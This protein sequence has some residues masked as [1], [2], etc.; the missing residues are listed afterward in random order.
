ML[1]SQ[2]SIEIL[3]ICIILIITTSVLSI[4]SFEPIFA[5]K[6]EKDDNDDD[7]KKNDKDRLIFEVKIFLQELERIG[8]LRITALINGQEVVKDIPFSE[9]NPSKN[10]VKVDLKVDKETD[11]VRAST[12]DEYHVCVYHVKNL[13][14][15]YDSLTKFD[16]NERDIQ[17]VS[18]TNTVSLFRPSS[19][20]FSKS[21]GFQDK[22]LVEEQE[23]EN[24]FAADIYDEEIE[25][26]SIGNN[27]DD[28]DKAILKIHAP[29]SDRKDTKKLK[30]MAMIKGQI[31]S[32]VVDDVKDEL[33]KS[34]GNTISRTF[35]FDR[36]TD[37]G[38]IQLGERF[39]ACVAS[40][41]LRPPEGQ[42][43]EKRLL[44]KFGKPNGLPAR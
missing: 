44:K 35:V 22:T 43:C 42:E 39:L 3:S 17:S 14:T 23:K 6:K 30:I 24:E 36:D 20:V 28:S 37:I 7:D 8:F 38:L 15:E 31:Q 1:I 12:N 27:N 41:D 26:S 25:G 16:C 11:I 29:L 4:S 33:K 10:T 32:E 18:S 34:K 21:E 5:Q 9:I 13:E 19:Q 2:K 40:D